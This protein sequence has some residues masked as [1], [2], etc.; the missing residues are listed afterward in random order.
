VRV[1]GYRWF[2]PDHP[3]PGLLGSVAHNDGWSPGPNAFIC[4]CNPGVTPHPAPSTVT[5]CGLYAF[6]TPDAAMQERSPSLLLAV[7]T[8]WGTTVLHRKGWRAEWAQIVALV[9]VDPSA[10]SHVDH[11]SANYGVPAF[12]V[13][14]P[15]TP[16]AAEI[17][18]LD[19]H[20]L[21][22][23]KQH[24]ELHRMNFPE[25]THSPCPH[26]PHYPQQSGDGVLDLV[27][28]AQLAAEFGMPMEQLPA[29][30]A[31]DHQAELECQRIDMERELRRREAER[32]MRAMRSTPPSP[33]SGYAR[34]QSVPAPP[35]A[36][37]ICGPPPLSPL[38]RHWL[39][40]LPRW[41]F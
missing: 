21:S 30:S 31:R 38:Q 3:S 11:L 25:C 2:R 37:G 5:H 28:L 39:R 8:G 4:Y 32:R 23:W 24:L 20:T 17:A 26:S 27:K 15:E 12:D 18:A 16:A 19:L 35:D 29:S 7:V 40:H 1:L 14:S 33:T 22:A 41:P 36:P 6:A 9:R 34:I 13:R 10:D